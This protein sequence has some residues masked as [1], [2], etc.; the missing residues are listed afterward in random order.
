[1]ALVGQHDLQMES[2]PG[3]P[4][5]KRFFAVGDLGRDFAPAHALGAWAFPALGREPAHYRVS[6]R[7][8]YRLVS[9][10][11][12]REVFGG[13]TRNRLRLARAVQRHPSHRIVLGSSMAENIE[14]VRAAVGGE[15]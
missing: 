2:L 3:T 11:S 12:M 6:H 10:D 13:G 5:A 15:V 8:A 4:R 9:T 14:V 7:R 1:M